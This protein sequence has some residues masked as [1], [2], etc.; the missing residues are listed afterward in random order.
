MARTKKTE[1]VE[2]VKKTKKSEIVEDSKVEEFK[3]EE[4]PELTAHVIY[5]KGDNLEQIAKLLT[6]H[7]YMMYRLVEV[8][9]YTMSNIPDGAILKWKV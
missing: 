8:N 1:K 2:E 4:V 6:G 7:A 9:G 3:T 5:H